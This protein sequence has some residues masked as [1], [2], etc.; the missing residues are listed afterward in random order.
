MDW[1]AI[2][3]SVDKTSKALIVHEDFLTGG[4]GAEIA[5]RLAEQR[6]ES[7]DGPVMRVASQDTPVPFATP[8][9]QAHLPTLDKILEAARKLAG[10]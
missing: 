8:L 3:A 10:Y 5:S 9:E 6:F 7:L 4:I 2:Y 1:D